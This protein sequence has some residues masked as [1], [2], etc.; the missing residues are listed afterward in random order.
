MSFARDFDNGLTLYGIWMG[1]GELEV[2]RK[3]IGERDDNA[4]RI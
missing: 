1:R 3:E 4:M 2:G